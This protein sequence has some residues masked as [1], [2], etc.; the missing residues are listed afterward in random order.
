MQTLLNYKRSKNADGQTDGQTAFQLYSRLA[1]VPTLS[2]RCMT[3]AYLNSYVF[4]SYSYVPASN[5][6]YDSLQSTMPSY[7]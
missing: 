2:C 3:Y 1:S 5:L 7:L 4:Y 6:L